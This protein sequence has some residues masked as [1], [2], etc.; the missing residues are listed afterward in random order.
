MKVESGAVI[1]VFRLKVEA[2]ERV[3]E[4]AGSDVDNLHSSSARI[5]GYEVITAES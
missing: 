2:G 1:R 3:D 4:G 5:V